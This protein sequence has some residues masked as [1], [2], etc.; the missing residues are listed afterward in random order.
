MKG[1]FKKDC[2]SWDDVGVEIKRETHCDLGGMGFEILET[3]CRIWGWILIIFRRLIMK[4]DFENLFLLLACDRAAN[5]V[6]RRLAELEEQAEKRDQGKGLPKV[7]H[8][9]NASL[10]LSN[11]Q[12]QS[13]PAGIEPR[14]IEKV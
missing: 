3:W 8:A 9:L 10:P 13:L 14:S 4:F 1:I 7:S 2:V 11:R 12:V 6:R 5:K